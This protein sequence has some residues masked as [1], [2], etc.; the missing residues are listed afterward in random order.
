MK[1]FLSLFLMTFVSVM[2]FAA[3][4][5]TVYYTAPEATIGTYNVKLNVNFKGDGDDWHQFDMTK[6]ALTYNGDPVYSYKYTD[7][8]DGV[9]VMQFQLFDG[10]TWKS[11]KEAITSWTGVATYNGKMYVHATEQWVAAPAEGGSEAQMNTIYTWFGKRGETTAT[12][13]IEAGGTAA[14]YGGNSNIVVGAAQKTNWTIKLNKGF[15]NANFVGITLDKA[16]AAGDKLQVAAFRTS[17][18]G[19]VFGIDFSADAESAATTCQVLFPDNLQTIT[20]NVAPEDTTF[21][22]PECAAGAKFIRIYR[23][24][25]STGIYVANFTILREKGDAPEPVEPLANGYYLVG[26][27]YDW[28]PAAERILT[29]NPENASE[30]M[31]SATLAV[32]DSLK[33]VGVENDVITWYPAEG[34]N[35]VVDAAHAGEKTIYFRPDYQGGKDWHY[36]CIFVPANEEPVVVELQA[37]SEATTWDFSKIT[38]NTGNALYNNDGIK[39]TDASTPTK[40]EEVVYANYSADFMTFAEGFDATTMAFKG[41][42]PIRKNQYCQ[43]G[44]LRF[45]TTV[46]GTI[47]VKFSDTGSSASATAVKRYLVVNGEQTEYWTSRQNNGEEPYE[48]Q[49]DVTSGEIAVPAG[50]VTITGSSAIVVYNVTFAP[51]VEVP[52]KFYITGDAALVGEELAWHADAIKVT[53]DSYTFENLAAGDYKLKVTD[54]AWSSEETPRMNLGF[55]DLTQ[56]DKAGLTAD[57]DNNIC[58]TLA[59]AGNVVVAYTSE[60]FTLSG[61]FYVAPVEPTAKFYITG[62]ANLVGEENEWQPNAIPVMEDSKVLAL[63]AGDYMLKLTMNGTWE[64]ENNVKGYDALTGEIPAGVTRGTGNNDDNICFTLAEAGNVTITY[65]AEAFTIEGDFY[66]APVEEGCDWENIEFLG[67]G[68]PEQT[69]GSQFKICKAG[70]QPNVGNIQK[71]GWAAETGIYVSF[72][73]AVFGEISLAEG[74]YV[75]EGAGMVLYLSAFTQEYTEVTVN[76]DGNDIV[77]TVY[78]AAA[79]PQPVEHTYTVAGGSD[80]A[81]GTAWDPENTA[82]DMVKQEDGTY[83]WEKTEVELPAGTISFK[84]VEDHSWDVAYPASDYNLNIAEQGEYTLTITFNPETKAVDA[85]ATKTGSAVV[86][87]TI[88]M[89][90]NFL[91]SWADTENFTVAE[92]DATAS[93]TLTLEAGNYEFGMR[94]GGSG[95]WTANGAAFTRENAA[96]VIEAG[97]GN[98]TLAADEAGKYTFT[99]TFAT[100]SLAIEFPEGCDWDNIDFLGD[101]SPEQTFGNQFKICKAGDQPNVVNIQKPDFAEES[102]IYVTFPSAAFGEISLAEGQYVIN[103]AGMVLYLSAFTQEYTEVTVNWDGNDIVFTV[104][105]AKA[106]T[107]VPV[108]NYYVIGSMTGWEVSEDYILTPNNAAEGQEFMGEFTFA[109]N[110]EFKVVK[111]N[112]EVW[113]PDGSDNNYVISEAGDYTVYFRPNGDGG[114]GWHHGYIYA[115]KK[116]AT[117][118]SNT[119]ADAEAVKILNN[120]M[121]LIRKGDKTYNVMGQA[122]K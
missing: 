57:K 109:A 113:F 33:V 112:K 60:A 52:A 115:A 1:K 39:L 45:K 102:G 76:W 17:T 37:V 110:A 105:N 5:T 54:G 11:Q 25:G 83:K 96:H 92:G 73:S 18:S 30:Y 97:S 77:F 84:I 72:P 26:D 82:N 13:A 65:T 81:F 14:A 46:A 29:V 3:T 68:S 49:L 44:T 88:A 42:Y 35:Y 31:I 19:A 118:I 93:L 86:I 70:D 114:E 80:V 10:E 36:G 116:E 53:E 4:E 27:K 121:L 22:V 95:N 40:N 78:N 63:E 119:A 6:T 8:Y 51:K 15:S 122:V 69:F 7:A 47:T 9:G 24:S 101:G 67:D 23:N 100:N 71:P 20:T 90:G 107:P 41:E 2:M 43:A 117:A 34:G 75:I 104:Y 56:E 111:N 50:D 94:I 98:L 62:S 108:A 28:T 99:W 16:L 55:S 66:V 79:A 64:G 21:T 106:V 38:A 58:F 61:N 12:E 32:D 85:V 87:P 59:E 103:G 74:Q 48:A 89:H 120:G 91:G